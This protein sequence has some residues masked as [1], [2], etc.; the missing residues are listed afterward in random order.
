[1]TVSE[2]D[3][4]VLSKCQKPGGNLK[5]VDVLTIFK[6]VLQEQTEVIFHKILI[7]PSLSTH[8]S[9]KSTTITHQNLNLNLDRDMR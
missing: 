1:M 4:W 6:K 7:F 8:A 5:N 9:P 3:I 2:S